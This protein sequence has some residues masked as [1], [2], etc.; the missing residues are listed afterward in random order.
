MH[1]RLV[2]IVSYKNLSSAV[3]FPRIGMVLN[4][5]LKKSKY[6]RTSREKNQWQ[7]V[8]EAKQYGIFKEYI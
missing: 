4:A 8:E 2:I 1:E 6:L 3:V 5:F 7:S